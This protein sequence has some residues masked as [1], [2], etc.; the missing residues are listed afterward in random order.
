MIPA[1][2]VG[3]DV[4]PAQ[5]VNSDLTKSLLDLLVR[6]ENF[7]AQQAKTV[8]SKILEQHPGEERI[9]FSS[10]FLTSVFFCYPNIQE[11]IMRLKAIGVLQGDDR[12]PQPVRP[13]QIAISRS[14][15]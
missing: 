12:R 9:L 10:E 14:S 8:L 11:K 1:N 13:T 5:N 4:S 6:D 7:N 15:L 3:Q 2:N